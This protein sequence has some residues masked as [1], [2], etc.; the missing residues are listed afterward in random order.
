MIQ[1][2]SFSLASALSS[3]IFAVI[4]S[5]CAT[6]NGRQQI[7][8]CQWKTFTSKA[9]GVS[10]KYNKCDD[11]KNHFDLRVV[12][13]MIERRR[14]ASSPL[15]DSD[16]IL[17]IFEKPKQESVEDFLKRNFISKLSDNSQKYCKVVR[18]KTSK[19]DHVQRY[20][21]NP[22]EFAESICG[23]YTNTG[24]GYFEYR[25]KDSVKKLAY[26]SIAHNNVYVDLD[27][28]SFK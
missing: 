3:L 27:S 26:V 28:L 17:E 12:G 22:T 9:H 20:V 25:P 13:H 4:L 18:L 10:L 24:K 2:L 1:K 23:R 14:P 8:N 19:P 5:S 15:R 11:K 16:V 21:I 7:A 6:K